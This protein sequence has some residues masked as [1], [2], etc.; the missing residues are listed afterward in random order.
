MKSCYHP[1]KLQIASGDTY[2][3]IFLADDVR[4]VH[5]VSRGAEI[6]KFLAGKDVDGDKVHLCVAVLA[7]L[8]GGHLNNLARTALDHD[9]PV[10]TQ[11]RALH[12][13]GQRCASVG[14]FECVFMLEIFSHCEIGIANAPNRLIGFSW[15]KK[16]YNEAK[17]MEDGLLLKRNKGTRTQVVG[18]G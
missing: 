7:S 15:A 3:L 12:R 6:L 13:I 18:V 11:S 1:V 16:E 2:K 5:V 9:V 14:I 10:L 4:D 17:K 8:G